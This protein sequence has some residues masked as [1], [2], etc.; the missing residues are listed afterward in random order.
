[1]LSR[2]LRVVAPSLAI[3]LISLV[4]LLCGTYVQYVICIALIAGITGASLVL[5][6]GL[7]RVIML[8]TGAMGAIGAYTSTLFIEHFRFPY[9]LAIGVGGLF[10][11]FGGFLL[12]IPAGRFRGHNLAMVTLV[13]QAIAVIGI[14]ELPGTGGSEGM[15]VRPVQMFGHQFN[16]DYEYLL[17]IGA[18]TALLAFIISA[19]QQGR[20]GNTLKAIAVTEIGSEAFGI[21][22]GLYRIV[23]FAITSGCLAAAGGLLAPRIRILDPETFGILASVNALA[24]P[25]VGGMT[26]VWGGLIGGG[27][28]S[29]LPE[30]LRPLAEYKALI[31][32]VL[33]ILVIGFFPGGILEMLAR[34]VSIARRKP[35]LQPLPKFNSRTI[36]VDSS[37]TQSLSGVSAPRHGP[38]LE[39][40]D[41]SVSFGS[42][43]AVDHVTLGVESGAIHGL[44]GPNG[45]G[46]TS[47]FNV[48][49]GF[50]PPDE[51]QVRF[52]GESHIPGAARTYVARGI[53]RT[54]QHVAIYGPLS[55]LENVA[56]GL[57][58]NDIIQSIRSSFV[59]PFRD[60]G[61]IRDRQSAAEA[62]ALVG[63]DGRR[64][65]TASTLS[66]GD[67]RRLEIA[68]AIV[69]RPRLLLLDEPMS[70]ISLDEEQ[71][72]LALLQ[73]L[74]ARLGLTMFLIEHNIR[75]VLDICN[76]LSVMSAGQIIA[77]G[78]PKDVI[79][80][81]GVRRIYFGERESALQ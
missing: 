42:L 20:F 51:G 28:L 8:A 57:G 14:R 62:L 13:F 19:L 36:L 41:V 5:L 68:R 25:I 69:S 44:I 79:A 22:I 4:G 40:S 33:V 7:G 54:F 31:F 59:D 55:C 77:D 3:V 66:L 39:I 50:L 53:T 18:C 10:G 37:T 80:Q 70:G 74:N 45:A 9:L 43:R 35:D 34:I 78:A 52:F 60:P 67:Q 64:H 24:Y 1:M 21:N 17:L 81:P 26:S 27:L 46:K 16:A 72:L 12:A 63:L 71:K 48:I 30:V 11:A 65:T 58:H 23:T 38:A 15:R 29:I 61:G 76:R 6:V 56:I 73:D 75:F 32:A 47:L 2:V 49:S